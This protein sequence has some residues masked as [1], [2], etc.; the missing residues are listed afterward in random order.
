MENMVLK[1]DSTDREVPR[2]LVKEA[3]DHL[4]GIVEEFFRKHP[5]LS[6]NGLA[7]KCEVSEPTLRRLRTGQGKRIPNPTTIVNLLT[8]ISKKSSLDEVLEYYG[9]PL[10]DYLIERM[11]QTKL[12]S[13]GKVESPKNLGKEL[14]TITKYLAYTIASHPSGI[15]KCKIESLFGFAA[16]EEVQELVDKGLLIEKDDCFYT[17]TDIFFMPEETLIRNAKTLLNFVKVE[18]AKD[19]DPKLTPSLGMYTGGVNKQTYSKILKIQQKARDKVAEIL[20]A[21]E[22]AGEISVF[23]LMALDTLDSK[24]AEEF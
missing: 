1:T 16:L 18:K 10:S 17:E 7:Q 5:N 13:F 3:S 20:F 12:K 22:N 2:S 4:K 11:P 9:P 23:S 15:S 24:T 8:Y 6:T 21:P 19:A 14:D